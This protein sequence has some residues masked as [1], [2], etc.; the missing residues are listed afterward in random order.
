MQTVQREA[1]HDAQRWP[2]VGPHAINGFPLHRSGGR[3]NHGCPD[4]AR[5]NTSAG[6]LR[7]RRL[8]ESGNRIGGK[9]GRPRAGA[10]LAQFLSRGIG[11]P[12]LSGRNYRHLSELEDRT[13]G[14]A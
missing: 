12:V 10:R 2:P 7:H 1:S 14:E 9:Q 8:R 11:I 3:R 6:V 4:D 13:H 5:G